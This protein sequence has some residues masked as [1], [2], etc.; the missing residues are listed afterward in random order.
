MLEMDALS[1]S[2]DKQLFLKELDEFVMRYDV[3][4][5][6]SQRCPDLI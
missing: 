4:C 6:D 1:G 3:A 2:G 5:L